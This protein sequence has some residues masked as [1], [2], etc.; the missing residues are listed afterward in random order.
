MSQLMTSGLQGSGFLHLSN[1]L[2]RA[3]I[4]CQEFLHG[5]EPARDDGRFILFYACPEYCMAQDDT[6][7]PD[8]WLAEARTLLRFVHSHR[9]HSLLLDVEQCLMYP[10]ECIRAISQFTGLSSDE[11]TSIE[12]RKALSVEVCCARLQALSGLMP[13]K[14]VEAAYN[15]LFVTA[16]P[17]GDAQYLPAHERMGVLAVSLDS[18]VKD[19]AE[20]GKRLNTQ[21]QEH[22]CLLLDYN[23]V[24]EELETTRKDLLH[25]LDQLEKEKT[26]C[27]LEIAGLKEELNSAQKEWG[28]SG[29][30]IEKLEKDQE[31][32]RLQVNHLQEELE[33][34]YNQYVQLKGLPDSIGVKDLPRM[35]CSGR[36]LSVLASRAEIK[37]FHKMEHCSKLKACL[38]NLI[39]ADG[40]YFPELSFKLVAS[41]GCAGVELRQ[42]KGLDVDYVRWPEAMK[43]ELGPYLLVI[44]DPV[45]EIAQTQQTLWDSLRTS[46]YN[47]LE[48]I[49]QAMNSLWSKN[50]VE[51]S[52]GLEDS[53]L[54]FWKLAASDCLDRFV[55][56]PEKMRYDH[57]FVKEQY[58]DND[59]EHLWL[60]FKN[61]RLG[62]RFFKNYDFKLQ[63]SSL[64]GRK[65]FAR[66][67]SLSFRNIEGNWAPPLSFWPPDQ[68]DDFGAKLEYHLELEK[69][70][71][72]LEGAD[73]LPHDD[74][75]M[76]KLLV[77]TLPSVLEW[78][79]L[80]V[81]EG[82]R[83]L[84][85]WRLLAETGRQTQIKADHRKLG[86]LSRV[87]NI[88]GGRKT[89]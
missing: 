57:A 82:N 18:L 43:D 61:M 12:P 80:S 3:G 46:D 41:S 51:N 19:I 70:E 65:A 33:Y 59:Y 89:Q 5:N 32:S 30:K 15:D 52:H 1:T 73:Q 24:H 11:D 2:S 56:K 22:E 72:S 16:V 29:E 54:R 87:R 67:M 49:L 28:E 60:A 7:T 26:F 39:L 21:I 42:Q 79:E 6:L 23:Q 86:T 53:K 40:R 78:I 58:Q 38:Y 84:E 75:E 44:P 14:D 50:F 31:L 74:V 88:L 55:H 62:D 63:A 13:V 85:Q 4:D 34:Y 64:G 68:A 27:N 77:H 76:I 36:G 81:G 17:L 45:L 66:R 35:I 25:S 8:A 69:A 83:Q 47:L 71:I 9:N 10:V 48:G 37:G 20:E